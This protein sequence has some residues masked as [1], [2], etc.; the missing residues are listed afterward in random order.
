MGLIA[1][2]VISVTAAVNTAPNFY[3]AESWQ[4]AT[5]NDLVTCATMAADLNAQFDF[6]VSQGLNKDW[7]TKTATCELTPDGE[8]DDGD[9]AAQPSV[10]Q[11]SAPTRSNLI[12]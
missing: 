8:E 2:L 12:F 6:L 4:G 9:D 7:Q 1:S 11:I 10:L 3:Q 5:P